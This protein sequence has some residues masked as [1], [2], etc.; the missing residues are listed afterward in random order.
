MGLSPKSRLPIRKLK[1][2]LNRGLS[3]E[4]CRH[5]VERAIW[6]VSAGLMDAGMGQESLER[7]GQGPSSLKKGSCLQTRLW[8]PLSNRKSRSP[9]AV[10][11][12]RNRFPNRPAHPKNL[13]LPPA[14]GLQ[15]LFPS[16]DL[17]G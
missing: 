9:T 8:E 11:L 5:V 14:H 1:E 4:K 15:H 16:N 3:A 7:S 13:Q 10:L 2:S 12:H 6:G 17:L